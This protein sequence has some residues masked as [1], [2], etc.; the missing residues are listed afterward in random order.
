MDL[1]T[2]YIKIPGELVK[3]TDS[4]VPYLLIPVP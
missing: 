2:Q 3:N 4:Q 1:N